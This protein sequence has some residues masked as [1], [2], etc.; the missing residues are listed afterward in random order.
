AEKLEQAKA[1]KAI[2]AAQ[3]KGA[4]E[5]AQQQGAEGQ[6]PQ[7]TA[8]IAQGK[9]K[10]CSKPVESWEPAKKGRIDST[11]AAEGEQMGEQKKGSGKGKHHKKKIHQ[12]AIASA[13]APQ[14]TALGDEEE[15]SEGEAEQRPKA[16]PAGA[17]KDGDSKPKAGKGR[18]KAKGKAKAKP[19]ERKDD[20]DEDKYEHLATPPPAK[21]ARATAESADKMA[22]TDKTSITPLQE[23]HA[24]VARARPDC[25]VLEDA[26]GMVWK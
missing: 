9:R 6:D 1:K 4:R 7:K 8:S 10:Q 21:K 17:R 5:T 15:G 14:E 16:T 22:D 25:K 3:A 13:A 23:C 20:D 18:P 26:N 24:R 19:P 11:A 12:G 2:D